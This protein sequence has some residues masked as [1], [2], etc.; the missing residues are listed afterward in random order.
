[1]PTL[2]VAV[3]ATLPPGATVVLEA[4]SARL[5]ER[6]RQVEYF[7]LVLTMSYSSWSV[8]T[9]QRRKAWTSQPDCGFT[10]E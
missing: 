4:A 1:M 9:S 8:A 3:I 6:W 2:S 7:A 5:V 10:R